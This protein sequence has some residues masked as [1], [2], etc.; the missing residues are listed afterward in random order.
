MEKQCNIVHPQIVQ[1]PVYIFLYF[2]YTYIHLSI[3]IFNYLII[4]LY[5]SIY[6][7]MYPSIQLSNKLFT[8]LYIYP[9]PHLPIYLSMNTSIHLQVHVLRRFRLCLSRGSSRLVKDKHCN[10]FTE[11]IKLIQAG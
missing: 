3:Y 1:L 6:L 4:H 2:S 7:S 10:S 9:S 11:G 5:I 8:P